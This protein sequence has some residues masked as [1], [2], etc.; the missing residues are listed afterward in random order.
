MGANKTKQFIIYCTLNDNSLVI[1]AIRGQKQ[2]NNSS[3]GATDNF[4]K[5][6]NSRNLI[7]SNLADKFSTIKAK[8]NPNAAHHIASILSKQ[9]SFYGQ[10]HSPPVHNSFFNMKLSPYTIQYRSLIPD[11][12]QYLITLTQVSKTPPYL[13]TIKP[14]SFKKKQTNSSSSN[15]PCQKTNNQAPSRKRTDRPI[16]S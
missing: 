14:L 11:N 9:S 13:L 7:S 2:A 6:T 8:E 16:F 5:L 12:H 10:Y 1:L 4:L 15:P 3:Q